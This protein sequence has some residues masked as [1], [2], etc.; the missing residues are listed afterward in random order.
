MQKNDFCLFNNKVF[1]VEEMS[2]CREVD[3]IMLSKK[4]SHSKILKFL[5]SAQRVLRFQEAHV[6]HG[7]PFDPGPPVGDYSTQNLINTGCY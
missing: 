6:I 7:C 2:G 4:L 1:N 3:I 5:P